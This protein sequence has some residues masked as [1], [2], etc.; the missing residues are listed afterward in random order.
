MKWIKRMV[1]V[2]IALVLVAVL[3][4]VA[5]V[6]TVNPNDYKDQ[7]ASAVYKETGRTVQFN[8][9]ISLSLFPWLGVT[10]KDVRLGNAIGFSDKTMLTA[11]T[12]EAKAAVLPLLKGQFE[13]GTLV[14]SGA[15]INLT[16]DKSGRTNWADLLAHEQ[17]ASVREPAPA[18]AS[19]SSSGKAAAL[20]IGGV[21]IQDATLN[22]RDEV[23]GQSAQINHAFLDTGSITPNA[24]IQFDLHFGYALQQPGM[25]PLSGQVKLGAVVRADLPGQVIT[26]QG[27]KLNVSLQQGAN[28]AP[29]ASSLPQQADLEFAAP[30]LTVSLAKKSIA[31]PAF[32]ATVKAS[33][34]ASLTHAEVSVDGDLSGNWQQGIYQSKAL[35]I[36]STLKGLGT[37]TGEVHVRATGGA[38]ANLTKGTADLAGWKVTSDPVVLTT[39][40]KL[41]GLAKAHGKEAAPGISITGPLVIASFNPRQLA[42]VMKYRV[43]VMQSDKALTQFALQGRVQVT[44][45]KALLDDLKIDLDG[46]SFTGVA[47]L[48]DLKSQRL[49]L[50]LKGGAFNANPYLPPGSATSSAAG[51]SAGAQGASG[52]NR[53]T[54]IPDDMPIPLPIEALRKLNA[55]IGV[56]LTQLTYQKYVLKNVVLALTAAGG[57][58]NLSKLDFDAFGG[59][60]QS[61][62]GLDV[63]G[64]VPGWRT[65]LTTQHIA[66]EPALTAAMGSSRISGTGDLNVDVRAQGDR[67]SALKSSLDGN[68]RFALKNGQVKGIDLGYMLRSA[69][70]QLQG[71]TEAVPKN[72]ATD[73]STI[74]GSAVITN[75]L[76]RNNDLQGA[77]PL[78]RVAGKG[79]VDLARSTLD[80]LLT[81]IV[82]NTATGQGGKALDKLKKLEIPIKITGTFAQ[83]KF[84]IDLQ[85]LLQGQAKQKVQDKINQE[86]DKRLGNGAAPVKNLLKG[87]GL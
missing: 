17:A 14:L 5:F 29:P 57:Q 18:A 61:Q 68:A 49:Y 66:L 39:S 60:I 20:A 28:P 8:G 6:A 37:H 62:A 16:R 22:W 24:P 63:R 44:P 4:A 27:M 13:I 34:L 42:D 23:T 38:Q 54:T 47:G 76:V 73:F 81:A 72:Q 31:L 21:S 32:S 67:L 3:A 74:T 70:A 15:T 1:M 69:Q 55:D 36:D 30:D 48:T 56:Q 86:L 65:K 59:A 82:V 78:L 33:R 40:L 58:I 79:T 77:S 12:V 25:G 52:S 11:Q 84:G 46:Q 43:P 19:P 83:P 64:S 45:S 87:F 80:Y 10:L 85:G 53:A 41:T 35:K 26:A 2:V 75:G 51:P 50:R 9:P 7:I 71:G